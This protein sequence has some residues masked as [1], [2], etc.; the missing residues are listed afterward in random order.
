MAVVRDDDSLGC[1]QPEVKEAVHDERAPTTTAELPEPAH[2]RSVVNR[3]WV[4]AAL[5]VVLVAS[6]CGGSP[7][8]SAP[9]QPESG[10]VSSPAAP[11]RSSTPA[12]TASGD[13][14][15]SEFCTAFKANG[16][17][18][19]TIGEPPLFYPKDKLINTA[20]ET[21]SVMK[22]LTPPAKIAA[23][24]KAYRRYQ[25]ELLALAKKLP[26]GGTLSG[27]PKQKLPDYTKI[28]HWISANC[29]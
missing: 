16:G 12:A 23:E 9:S 11:S 6:G 28:T 8:P 22:G 4:V 20:N 29:H 27:P 10:P 25:E 1:L 13:P 26:K 14:V 19:T 15:A 3:L 5:L 18:L 21:L 17:T 7:T 24:W 2:E